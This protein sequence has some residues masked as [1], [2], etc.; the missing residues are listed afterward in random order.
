MKP[1]TEALSQNKTEAAY[2]EYLRLQ[3]IGGHILDFRF[4]PMRLVL[5]HAQPGKAKGMT[6]TPDFLVVYSDRFEFHEVKGFWRDDARAKIKMAAEIFPWFRFLAV[7]RGS[8]KTGQWEIE[9]I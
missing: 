1:L 8:N 9:L 6:Y 3:K 4:E 2:A 7:K 5:R